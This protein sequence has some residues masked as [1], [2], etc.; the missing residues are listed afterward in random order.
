MTAYLRKVKKINKGG[1]SNKISNMYK[2]CYSLY[3]GVTNDDELLSAMYTDSLTITCL[4]CGKEFEITK[5]SF[6][7]GDPYCQ[8]CK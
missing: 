7:N 6:R 1:P 2:Q 5:L 3:P 8:N 4:G